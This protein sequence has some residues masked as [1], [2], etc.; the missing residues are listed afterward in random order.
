MPIFLALML[1]EVPRGKMLFRTLYYLPAVTS[2][3]VIMF[4]WKMFYDP[5]PQGLFNTDSSR[6]FAHPAADM[7]ER[8]ATWRCSA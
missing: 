5:T 8:F 3:L 7:A 1:S 2:G 4:L 6:C